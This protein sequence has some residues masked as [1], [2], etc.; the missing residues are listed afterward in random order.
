MSLSACSAPCLWPA[1]V[2]ARNS[3]RGP[4]PEAPSPPLSARRCVFG[5]RA[6]EVP[7]G[8]VQHPGRSA[9]NRHENKSSGLE[10]SDVCLTEWATKIGSQ[11]KRKTSKG[12]GDVCAFLRGDPEGKFQWTLGELAAPPRN[13]PNGNVLNGKMKRGSLK[14]GADKVLEIYR[15]PKVLVEPSTR[16]R[17]AAW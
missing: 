8:N 6:Q 16:V 4:F 15:P 14:K 2:S 13:Q 9:V 7:S 5:G 11:L 12:V 17:N 10:K 1:L 3:R